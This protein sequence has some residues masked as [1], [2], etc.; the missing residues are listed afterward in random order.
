MRARIVTALLALLPTVASAAELPAGWAARVDGANDK[1]VRSARVPS[2]DRAVGEVRLIQRGE[3][4]V[5]ETLLYTKVLRRVVAEINKKEFDNWP[6]GSAGHDEA[7]RYV[8]SLRAV[9]AD[10]W[11]RSPKGARD[12]VTQKMMIDFVL[13]DSVSGVAIGEYDTT[14]DGEAI[15]VTV[16]RPLAVLELSRDYARRNMR[17]IVADAFGLNDADLAA[18][19]APFAL[20]HDKPAEGATP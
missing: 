15:A 8:D 13:G 5:V 10:I 16:R 17:L 1:V 7:S 19:L 3:L 9:Q 14:G 11:S 12:G 18:V 4:T 2:P 6:E 20:L